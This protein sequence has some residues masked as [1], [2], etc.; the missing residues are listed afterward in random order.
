MQDG[1]AN[2]LLRQFILRGRILPHM[3]KATTDLI[4]VI[5]LAREHNIE[6]VCIDDSKQSLIGDSFKDVRDL[7]RTRD[8]HMH[9]RAIDIAMENAANGKLTLIH[10]GATHTDS[11]Q[12]EQITHGNNEQRSL[13]YKKLSDVFDETAYVNILQLPHGITPV[14]PSGARLLDTH[15]DARLART[16]IEDGNEYNPI[17]GNFDAVIFN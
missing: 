1:N 6:I 9:K 13:P 15:L 4:E 7:A 8:A 14:K 3:I 17:L 2:R 10:E 16:K 11:R 5:T 12:M